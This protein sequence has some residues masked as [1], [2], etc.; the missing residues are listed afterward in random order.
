MDLLFERGDHSNPRGHALLYFRVDTEP[1]RVYV[2]YVVTLPIKA[3]LA[4]YV[5]PFLASHLGALPLNELSAFAMPPVP[6]AVESYEEIDRLSAQRGDDLVYGGN[7]FSF[8]LPRMMETVTDAV[9]SY[10]ALYGAVANAVTALPSDAAAE[11][12]APRQPE[13]EPSEE[14][15]AFGVNEVLFSFMSEGDK[16]NELSRL[17]GRLRFA[18]EGS[19]SAAADEAGEEIAVLAR[20]LP[21]EFRLGNLLAVAKDTSERSSQ[22]A[23]LYLDRCFRL[24]AGNTGEAVRL[25]QQI[26]E[27]ESQG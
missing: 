13:P 21:A 9:Q 24:S 17:L 1:D 5:P 15:R 14:E 11:A 12:A 2:S 23:K 7:M 10:S 6:E 4:K 19:D 25:E 3:D 27:L 20:H 16:L 26:Q 8:D 22:L 18:V